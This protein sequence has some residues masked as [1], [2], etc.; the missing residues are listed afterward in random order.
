MT[1]CISSWKRITRVLVHGHVKRAEWDSRNRYFSPANNVFPYSKRKNRRLY[2]SRASNVSPFSE[3]EI[4]ILF[5]HST[6]SQKF[7]LD[8]LLHSYK[9]RTLPNVIYNF[10]FSLLWNKLIKPVRAR[11]RSPKNRLFCPIFEKRT[12]KR[13][14]KHIS[15]WFFGETYFPDALLKEAIQIRIADVGWKR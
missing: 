14:R 7:S 6:F 4:D 15:K 13:G 5:W 10:Y 3:I 2:F 12:K 9:K 8:Y 1:A 11:Y